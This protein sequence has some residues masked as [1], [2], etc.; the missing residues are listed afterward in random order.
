MWQQDYHPLG[1]SILS[2]VVAALPI[3]VMLGGLGFLHMKAH[4]AAIAGLIVALVI[5]IFVY[6]MPSEMALKT[7]FMGGYFG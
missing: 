3:I 2:V 5:A 6:G 7:A 1:N 4:I